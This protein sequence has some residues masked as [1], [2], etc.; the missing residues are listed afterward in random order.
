MLYACVE[1]FNIIGGRVNILSWD[2]EVN[3]ARVA[4]SSL[5][6]LPVPSLV[7]LSPVAG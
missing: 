7:V 4:S 2:R 1:R 3:K 6:L 5:H